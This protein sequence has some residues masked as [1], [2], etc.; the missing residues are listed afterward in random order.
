[1][2]KLQDNGTGSGALAETIVI[3]QGAHREE[4]Q[5]TAL[6]DAEINAR[7]FILL[8]ICTTSAAVLLF[9]V[10]ILHG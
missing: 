1:M 4:S 9:A 2:K 5:T 6:S 7:L 3:H 10:R 8:G